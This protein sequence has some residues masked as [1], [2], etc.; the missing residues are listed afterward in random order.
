MQQEIK[1][2]Q[3]RVDDEMDVIR[4]SILSSPSFQMNSNAPNRNTA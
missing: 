3:K 1:Q 4:E 2:Y